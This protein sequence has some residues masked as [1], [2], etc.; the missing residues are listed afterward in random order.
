MSCATVRPNS[1]LLGR[2]DSGILVNVRFKGLL[3]T[4]TLPLP[5]AD[6]RPIVDASRK[7]IEYLPDDWR[8]PRCKQPKTKFNKA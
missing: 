7:V 4:D 1:D 8:C 3:T 6:N 2:V 5:L